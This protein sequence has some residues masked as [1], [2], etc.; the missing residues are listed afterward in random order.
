MPVTT[1]WLAGTG[2][3]DL[4]NPWKLPRYFHPCNRAVDTIYWKP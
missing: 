3:G 2:E 1:D 4:H